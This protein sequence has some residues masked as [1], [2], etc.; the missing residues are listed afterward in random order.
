MKA[1]SSGG[2]GTTKDHTRPVPDRGSHVLS[3]ELQYG[4]IG[5]GGNRSRLQL[6]HRW[7]RSSPAAVPSQKPA[8]SSVTAGSGAPLIMGSGL[9][10]EQ[11]AGG[12]AFAA[13]DHRE[14]DVVDLAGRR[15]ADLADALDDEVEPV[16]V[17]LGHAAA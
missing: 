15:T 7:M 1:G 11:G 17:R 13:R 9:P 6:L 16:Y 5:R 12:D 10:Q 4:H 14:V 8:E 3:S 2:C